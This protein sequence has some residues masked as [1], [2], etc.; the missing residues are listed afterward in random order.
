[1]LD[2]G[3]EYQRLLY[4][5][6]VCAKPCLGGCVEVFALSLIGKASVHNR[7]ES[8]F[9]S[10]FV[11]FRFFEPACVGL[12]SCVRFDQDREIMLEPVHVV[13]FKDV[14]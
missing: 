11:M 6:V 5:G 8:H 12:E 4:C 2:D 3:L 10:V 1:M 7:H 13:S 9:G 14:H